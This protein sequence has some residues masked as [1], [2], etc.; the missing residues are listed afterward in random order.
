MKIL[1]IPEIYTGGISWHFL[2][3]CLSVC[4]EVSGVWRGNGSGHSHQIFRVDRVTRRT[5]DFCTFHGCTT[6]VACG[7][8]RR[9]QALQKFLLVKPNGGHRR[10]QTCRP[11]VHFPNLCAFVVAV[12]EGFWLHAPEA[13]HLIRLGS[14][15]AREFW[16]RDT[17]LVSW[18]H[19]DKE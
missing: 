2:L 10:S 1:G 8:C 16:A 13:E 14:S 6:H 12:P 18:V 19:I 7:T 17:K 5:C 11:P 4:W 3:S 9:V 15:G